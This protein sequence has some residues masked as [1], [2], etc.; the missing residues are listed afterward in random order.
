MKSVTTQPTLPY[1]VR[2]GPYHPH[3]FVPGDVSPHLSLTPQNAY[4][5]LATNTLNKAN[6]QYLT[7]RYGIWQSTSFKELDDPVG[8][9][10]QP[11]RSAMIP[12]VTAWPNLP[13]IIC[14][15]P[16]RLHGFVPGDASSHLRLTPQNAYDK[17]ATSNLNKA[18][19]RSLTR[20]CGIW[21][22]LCKSREVY[23]RGF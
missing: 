5:K 23:R 4:D 17:L 8:T 1:I 19:H 10:E 20:R 11:V 21:Q 15:G 2:F 7:R 13:F 3:G 18:S 16:Y 22:N 14:F 12:N 9:T 6:Y